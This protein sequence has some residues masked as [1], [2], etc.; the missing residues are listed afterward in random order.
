M[1]AAAVVTALGIADSTVRK[2]ATQY[3]DYLSLSGMSSGGRH[4]DFTDHD[5][6]VLKLIVDMKSAKQSDDN[7]DL[8]LRSLQ[9]SGWDRLPALDD[10][11]RAIMPSPANVIAANVEK[12]AMQREIDLLRE[13]LDRAEE[14]AQRAVTEAAADRNDLV[15][16]L[17]EAETMLR[18]YESGRLKPPTE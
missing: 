3:N 11:S 13:M 18:L 17:A 2:Y 5:V 16:R 12:S 6:R 4:C 7:I 15:K 8:T 14:R 9:A 1:K 10:N